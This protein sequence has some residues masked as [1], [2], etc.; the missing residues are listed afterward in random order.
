MW[1]YIEHVQKIKADLVL[2]KKKKKVSSWLL[3]VVPF[4]KVNVLSGFYFF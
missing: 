1:Y 4:L 3:E 2:S